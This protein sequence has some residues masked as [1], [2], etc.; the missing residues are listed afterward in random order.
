[1]IPTGTVGREEERGQGDTTMG[2]LTT[3]RGQ[4]G[5]I[6]PAAAVDVA[7]A[8][9]MQQR[10]ARLIDVREP[11]E[12]AAGHAAGARNIPLGQLGA[13]LGDIPAAGPV[14]LIC[15]S[16]NRSGQAQ[17][18]LRR[19]GRTNTYNVTGGTAAWQAAGLPLE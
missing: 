8:R 1:M 7:G 16:G 12:F 2:F 17:E 9:E 13:R 15:R 11:R 4:G 14:L 3:L 5:T 19:Q 18:L 10:G 6:S